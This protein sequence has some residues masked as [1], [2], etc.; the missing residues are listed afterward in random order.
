MR[1]PVSTYRIGVLIPPANFACETEYPHSTPRRFSFHFSRLQ[2]PETAISAESLLAMKDSALSCAEG[3]RFAGVDVLAYACTSGSFLAGSG[4]HREI[5]DQLTSAL[6]VPAITTSTAVLEALR[7]LGARRLFVV[8]P[9]PEAVTKQTLAY[10]S[11]GGF[12]VADWHSFDCPDSRSIAAVREADV[13]EVLKSAARRYRERG[14]IDALLVSCT[15]LRTLGGL[16]A[17]EDQ[18]G[19]PVV[20]SNSATIWAA[21]RAVDATVP[22]PALG[23]LGVTGVP[24]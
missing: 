18:Y 19:M 11:V 17:W 23:R 5:S 6:G 16:A 21:I 13:I 20:S 15:N 1:L 22:L 4:S 24:A 12:E 2:R 9:Y 10:L 7:L 14:S 8:T 3:L